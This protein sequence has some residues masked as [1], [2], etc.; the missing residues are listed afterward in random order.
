[1][2]HEVKLYAGLQVPVVEI[3]VNAY[4]RSISGET[5]TANN[6]FGRTT[7]L[8]PPSSTGRTPLLEPRG[9][10]RRETLNILDLRLEK[11]FSIAGHNDRFGLYAD[12]TNV[13]NKG[14]VTNLATRVTGSSVSYVGPDGTAQSA[15]V[16]FEGP[17]GLVAPRQVTLAA[18]WSF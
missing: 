14:T 9:S 16:P 15:T 7:I 6:R 2:R 8:F 4:F 11:I 10:R 3:G 17:L 12:I 18:R 13:F 1:M 5:Y